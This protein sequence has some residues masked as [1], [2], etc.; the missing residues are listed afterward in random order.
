MESGAIVKRFDD[1]LAVVLN[2]QLD[3]IWRRIQWRIGITA[4]LRQ[5]LRVVLAAGPSTKHQKNCKQPN[6]AKHKMDDAKRC[7][8]FANRIISGCQP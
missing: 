2:F 6:R 5:V 1:I 7:V 4:T 3:F 8:A